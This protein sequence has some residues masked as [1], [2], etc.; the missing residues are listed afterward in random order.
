MKGRL[1]AVWETLRTSFWFLPA[2]MVLAATGLAF[3]TTTL[4]ERLQ[5]GQQN[6][7]GWI[8]SGNPEG[9]RAML[10]TIAGSML[11]V[12][13]LTFSITITALTLA[14]SQFGPRLLRNFIRDTGNQIV[15]GTFIAGF[16]YCLLVLRTVRGVED[17]SF[18]PQLSVTVGV[19]MALAGVAVL[20]YFIDHI[21]QSIQV[22]QLIA[23]VG[24]EL[25][26]AIDHLFP[27]E[28]GSGSGQPPEPAGEDLLLAGFTGEV[29]VLP[30]GKTGYLQTVDD[31]RLMELASADNLLVQLLHRPGDWVVADMPLA[32][33]WLQG[34]VKP[35]L[36]ARIEDVF[37]FGSRRTAT[38]DAQYM[39][40][41]LVEIAVR[42]LSPG[43]NDPHTAMMCIDR[44][45][46][47]LYRL[48]SRRQPSP[49]RYDREG[50]L[51]VIAQPST[52][53]SF[54]DAAFNEIR[55]YG[56][57]SVSVTIR[58]LETIARILPYI[59][60]EAEQGALL[61]QAETIE[62][63]SRRQGFEDRDRR[64]IVERYESVLRAAG[65]NSDGAPAA[66]H[67]TSPG[68]RPVSESITRGHG[69]DHPA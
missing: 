41:Q 6:G 55:Q 32:R 11:T 38:Q 15:L 47:A 18:V 27:E 3:L 64:D 59:S 16:M 48:A 19:G 69:A 42:A 44:L 20:I 34:D 63:A 40:D 57:S 37:V 49:Y 33:V 1:I 56:A 45:G 26:G 46:A 51:R 14:S 60:D 29:R 5:L 13:G 65:Q 21:A 10:S 28:I 66:G 31:S 67:G 61:N 39:I 7:Y 43:I 9:A 24:A 50:K 30:A 12:A 54:V 35:G 53:K 2:L 23:R 36:D 62:Q 4:D 52:R 8:Y 25:D 58:L 22:T 17:N 68:Y